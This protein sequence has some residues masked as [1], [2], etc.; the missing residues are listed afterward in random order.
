MELVERRIR[1][2]TA[3]RILLGKLALIAEARDLCCTYDVRKFLFGEETQLPAVK[4][5][6][7]VMRSKL[8]SIESQETIAVD[9]QDRKIIDAVR[10]EPK[11]II[12]IAMEL[13]AGRGTIGQR[14]EAL[15]RIGLIV[16]NGRRK[17]FIATQA[18]K[19]H[20][21]SFR[22]GQ[23]ASEA[24]TGR[25][26]L[27]AESGGLLQSGH[28]SSGNRQRVPGTCQPDPHQAR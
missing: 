11:C 22:R 23:G 14:M 5:F 26:A 9:H 3:L 2:V 24:L 18:G 13:E 10:I 15:S 1:Y 6:L 28:D 20:V 25:C 27:P 19:D 16:A 12:D 21:D 4:A 7:V 17:G 8:N